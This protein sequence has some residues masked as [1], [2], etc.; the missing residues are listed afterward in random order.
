MITM[1]I[2]AT[3]VGVCLA[4]CIGSDSLRAESD[5]PCPHT[6]NAEMRECYTKE[7]KGV[8]AETDLLAKRIAAQFRRDAK[9]PSWAGVVADSLRKTASAVTQSQKTWRLI[10]TS[11]AT[12]LLSVG[13]LG[14][15]LAPPTRAACSNSGKRDCESYDLHLTN[16]NRNRTRLLL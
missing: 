5:D 14:R 4:C 10:V 8:N 7:Q 6:S 1:K 12:R 13:R 2:T 9:D 15:A 11:T 3:I 16:R